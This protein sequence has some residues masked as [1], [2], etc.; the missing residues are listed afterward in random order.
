M[1]IEEKE[2]FFWKI[3]PDWLE[4]KSNRLSELFEK[5]KQEK[6]IGG[7]IKYKIEPRFVNGKRVGGQKVPDYTKIQQQI[8]DV[9][10][11]DFSNINSKILDIERLFS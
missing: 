2:P 7:G 8:K 6:I 10:D 5:Q 11:D 1:I 3:N 4:D 9:L